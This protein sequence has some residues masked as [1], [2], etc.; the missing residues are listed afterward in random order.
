MKNNLLKSFIG[1][2]LALAVAAG[3]ATPIFTSAQQIKGAQLLMS[4]A[5]GSPTAVR[6]MACPKCVTEYG[7]RV[8]ASARG[9]VKPV[10]LVANHLCG[11]CDTTVK[12]TGVGKNTVAAVSHTCTMGD[13]QLAKCCD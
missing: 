2:G 9:A 3:M 11:G 8:D 13:G 7:S 6:A 12:T 1:S 10:L 5:A 4:P